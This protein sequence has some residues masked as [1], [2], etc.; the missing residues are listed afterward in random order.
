M[1]TKFYVRRPWG[2][3]SPG[4]RI[5]DLGYNGDKLKAGGYVMSVPPDHVSATCDECVPA[6]EFMDASFRAQ[7]RRAVHGGL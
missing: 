7:H 4:E 6:R 1:T 2:H 5:E 3:Y